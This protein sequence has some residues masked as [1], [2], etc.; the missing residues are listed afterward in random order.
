M[1]YVLLAWL[2]SALCVFWA[3]GLF[4]VATFEPLFCLVGGGACDV[5]DFALW[6]FGMFDVASACFLD[7]DY[8]PLEF[9]EFLILWD[10]ETFYKLLVGSACD[11]QEA[12]SSGNGSE[13]SSGNGS[14]N[15]LGNSPRMEY[16]L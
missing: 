15:G 6:D 4:G 1:L 9:G 10:L 11:L 13:N 8:V 14:E 12:R 2:T 16:S 3:I 7:F 5:W